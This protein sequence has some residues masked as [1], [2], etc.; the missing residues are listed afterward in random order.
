MTLREELQYN[1]K[2]LLKTS[3][4]L[5]EG[6]STLAEDVLHDAIERALK[7]ENTYVEGDTFFN[8]MYYIMKNILFN[9]KRD[10][11]KHAELDKVYVEKVEHIKDL[12]NLDL[13][14]AIIR[15]EVFELFNEL[16][17]KKKD[18]LNLF[19]KGYSRKEI[20]QILGIPEGTVRSR[21]FYA[22][23]ELRIKLGVK[24]EEEN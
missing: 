5:T 11:I 14:S 24:V 1:Y 19:M 18:L 15:E 21:R 10:L 7:Y 2:T 13:D 20:S 4:R 12:S 3:L 9:K 6:N 8:W 17:D 23:R 22:I 16:P